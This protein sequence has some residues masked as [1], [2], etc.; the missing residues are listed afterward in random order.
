VDNW[1]AAEPLLVERLRTVLGSS[2]HVLT[3]RALAAVEEAGQPTPAVHVLY[4]GEPSIQ[5]GAAGVVT[6][7]TQ[8][9]LLV[10]CIENVAT[11]KQGA[12]AGQDAGHLAMRVRTA[13]TGPAWRPGG[14]LAPFEQVPSPYAA[15]YSS[16]RL[17]LPL[18][19]RTKF[20][21]RA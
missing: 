3:A 13:V 15:T 18:A 9:W 7:V 8:T 11:L 6:D 4:H 19:F 16:G 5:S 17:Y 2:A 21:L 1:L 20:Q 10:C 12:A 14:G